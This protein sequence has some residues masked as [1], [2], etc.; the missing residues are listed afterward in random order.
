V[1]ITAAHHG[2]TLVIDA[3]DP[4]GTMD[5]RV[6]DKIGKVFETE[7]KYEPHFKGEMIEDIGL[8]ASMKSKHSEHGGYSNTDGCVC[9]AKT[10]IK[11][12]I[13]WGVTGGYHSLSGYKA[14]I[15]PMLTE[16]D[17]YDNE[18]LIKYVEEKSY[19]GI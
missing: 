12:N 16:F 3:I 10:L 14:L 2:A 9:T 6:Y 15:A 1:Y 19:K 8:Y 11:N 4:V 18:R 7:E 17:E 5:S 13:L